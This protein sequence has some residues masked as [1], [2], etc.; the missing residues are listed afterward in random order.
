MRTVISSIARATPTEHR[1]RREIEHHRKLATGNAEKTW[2][3]ESP[4][5][6]ARA[7]RRARLFVT[8][9]RIAP[10]TRVLELGCGTGEFTRR[11]APAGARLI[12]LDLSEELLLKARGKVGRHVHFIRGNGDSLPFPDATFNAVYGC[13]VLHHMDVE[14]A[15]REVKRVLHPGGHL[16]FSEPN[17]LNPQVLLMFKCAPLKPRFGNSPDEMAFTRRAVSQ[18][19]HRLGFSRF[20]VSYFD[21]VHPA[22]PA[23]LVSTLEPLLTRLEHV[24][25][26]RAISGSMLIHA[27][28]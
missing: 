15:L 13:S 3:W 4:A 22:T 8:W 7:D 21:F 27:E 12:A 19:L 2:G 9:G 10:G 17:L 1:L 18:I 6:R 14:A 28:R 25:L 16:V 11:V 24:P 23:F 20:T 5:G 26:L